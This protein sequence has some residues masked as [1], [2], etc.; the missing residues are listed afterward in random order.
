[1]RVSTRGRYGLRV[2]IELASRFGKGPVQ[3]ATVARSLGISRK[4]LHSLLT[5]LRAAGL[6][7]STRGASGG[8]ELARPP[9]EITASELVHVLEGTLAPVE[10]VQDGKFCKRSATC[11]ARDVWR[12]MG[13]A[14]E[15]VLV[16]LNL[17]QLADRQERSQTGPMVFDI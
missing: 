1:M 8:Y 3:M 7:Q 2:M 10:C 15:K 16:G 13:E 17:Q 11:I 12:D 9:S 6:V 4:Y 5:S 14:M